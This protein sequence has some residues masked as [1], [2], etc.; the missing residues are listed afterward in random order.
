MVSTKLEGMEDNMKNKQKMKQESKLI[1]VISDICMTKICVNENFLRFAWS[2]FVTITH[3]EDFKCRI[4]NYD[5][6]FLQCANVEKLDN[7]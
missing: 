4:I 7:L 6:A 3:D 5:N 1:T 2:S